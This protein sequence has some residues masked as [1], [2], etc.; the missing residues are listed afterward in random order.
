MDL[1]LSFYL[2]YVLKKADHGDSV[3]RGSKFAK[4]NAP[5][6]N[7]WCYKLSPLHLDVSHEP[8]AC[9]TDDLFQNL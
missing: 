8:D 4:Q 1:V 9:D 5:D 7:L 3:K 6:G 2:P